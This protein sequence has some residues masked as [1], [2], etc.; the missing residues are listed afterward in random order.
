M[1]A[2]S[3]QK[4]NTVY[5]RWAGVGPYY[6]MFP[7]NFAERVIKRYTDDDDTILDPFAGRGT[8]V[9]S[10]A[11]EGRRGIGIEL[12]PVGWI[13]ARAKLQA[14][15]K[16][17]VLDRMNEIQR[18]A[19]RYRK[20]V[21]HLP[22]FF[23]Y[24]FV[25]SVREFLVA[26]RAMLNWRREK[27]D[28]TTMAL[29]LI[30]LHGKR[31]AALSNQMRQTKSMS[32]DYSISWWR[33]ERSKPPVVDP[34]E[35]MRTRIEWR[36]AKGR[37][38]FLDSKIYLGD[39]VKRLPQI[40]LKQEHKAQ[41]L[42]T[43]P[44]YCGVTNYHYDQWLRLWLL[45]GPATPQRREAYCC[46]RFSDRR[47]Y[48]ALLTTVFHAAAK[49][50][51]RDAVVYVRT[52]RREVTLSATKR[53]LRLA[54]PKKRLSAVAQPCRTPTQTALFGT[55]TSEVGEMDLILKPA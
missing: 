15:D 36:Y 40:A 39:S 53:A 9:F 28:W 31:D 49:L 17:D 1:T 22:E 51:S 3:P 48:E 50:L 38:S 8:T 5:G 55:V 30:Y 34:V 23:D 11:H 46:G 21:S 7:T 19:W 54:F 32:P 20:S 45:G 27:V 13:Y 47:R 18:E 12:N 25:S 44:P 37:P 26:A 24:C 16:A 33:R 41:L 42:L 35:F 2:L 14:A 43:S 6:A 52:D 4:Y 29:L 10:A